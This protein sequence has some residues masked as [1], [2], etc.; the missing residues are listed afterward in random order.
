MG[1][2]TIIKKKNWNDTQMLPGYTE[3]SLGGAA[4]LCSQQAGTVVGQRRQTP[5]AFVFMRIK[6]FFGLLSV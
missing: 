1:I 5:A 4:A 3:H 6:I 2:V